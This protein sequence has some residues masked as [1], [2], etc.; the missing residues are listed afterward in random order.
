M[1][2]DERVKRLVSSMMEKQ[3]RVA[4]ICAAPTALV[5]YGVLGSRRATVYPSLKDQ[6]GTATYVDEKVVVDGDI[7]TSQGP[8]TAID[9]A[10]KIVEIL[11]GYEKAKEVADRLLVE[12]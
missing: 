4:A 8:G 6:L 5:A 10:L 1:K 7:I 9:F 2:K 12:Y 3:R 11:L